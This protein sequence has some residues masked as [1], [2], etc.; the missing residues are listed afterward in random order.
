M[1]AHTNDKMICCIIEREWLKNKRNCFEN[2]KYFQ[3]ILQ[4]FQAVKCRCFFSNYS[5]QKQS[6]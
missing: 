6:R 1:I 4:S 2:C 3:L 5:S